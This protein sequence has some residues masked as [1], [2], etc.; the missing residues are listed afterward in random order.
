MSNNFHV[1]VTDGVSKK[2]VE[3]LAALPGVKVTESKSLTE[4]ELLVQIMDVD[5]LIVRS[6]TKVSKAVIQASNRLKV[7]G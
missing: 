3:L 7:V 6:Q 2:G 4:A 5:A 1:L